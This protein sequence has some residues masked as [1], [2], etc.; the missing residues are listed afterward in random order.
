MSEKGVGEDSRQ[1]LNCS[2]PHNPLCF[3]LPNPYHWMLERAP[4]VLNLEIVQ[5]DS[6]K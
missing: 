5:T 4:D 1:E 6:R 3:E 2:F